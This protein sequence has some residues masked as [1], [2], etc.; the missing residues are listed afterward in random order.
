MTSRLRGA[1]TGATVDLVERADAVLGPLAVVVASAAVAPEEL[2]G[3]PAS[4][5]LVLLAGRE[6]GIGPMSAL[7]AL[8]IVRGRVTL[9]ADA[10][11]ALV[12]T[13]AAC[14]AWECVESTAAVATYRTRRRGDAAWTTLAWTMDQ[15]R[16]AGIAGSGQWRAYPEAMLR[17]RCAAALARMVYPDLCAG[18]YDPDELASTAR[19]DSPPVPTEAPARLAEARRDDDQADHEATDRDGLIAAIMVIGHDA[20]EYT[21]T[22]LSRDGLDLGTAP[23]GRVQGALS[24]L[25]TERGRT[26][27]ADYVTRRDAALAAPVEYAS[28]DDARDSAGAR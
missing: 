12:R 13:S 1:P 5:L 23:L 16:A 2:R 9:A 27:L 7:R 15:A 19:V 25:S 21:E 10:L 26:A 22:V 3:D 18:V 17:A 6:L 4:T 8:R 28:A 11:V 14:E 24:Y 20:L